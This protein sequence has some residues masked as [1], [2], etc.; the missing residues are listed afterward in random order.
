MKL[1]TQNI[2]V[3]T[4]S[5]DCGSKTLNIWQRKHMYVRT[6]FLPRQDHQA[7][8]KDD[9]TMMEPSY[10]WQW[11]PGQLPTSSQWVFF[12]APSLYYLSSN[13]ANLPPQSKRFLRKN[14]IIKL[15]YIDKEEWETCTQENSFQYSKRSGSWPIIW[16]L[17]KRY[18]ISSAEKRQYMRQ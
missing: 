5:P 2:L 1:A 11:Q 6:G 8:R 18:S 12:W 10:W 17:S 7:C 13:K 3:H 14:N 9:A 16:F 15:I 4:V